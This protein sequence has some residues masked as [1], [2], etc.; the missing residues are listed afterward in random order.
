MN[1]LFTLTAVAALACSTL[2]T[3]AGTPSRRTIGRTVCLMGKARPQMQ[4][5]VRRALPAHQARPVI[6]RPGYGYSYGYTNAGSYSQQNGRPV[7]VPNTGY[8]YYRNYSYGNGYNNGYRPSAYG[9]AAGAACAPRPNGYVGGL[10]NIQSNI[11]QIPAAS[12]RR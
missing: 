2:A 10:R 9:H 8:G 7:C 3:H 5:Q 11:I 4:Y 12:G 1:K 6:Q